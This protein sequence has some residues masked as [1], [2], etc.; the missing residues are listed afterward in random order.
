[1]CKKVS[2]Y[3][4]LEKFWAAPKLGALIL[5]MRGVR[6]TLLTWEHQKST[7]NHQIQWSWKWTRTRMETSR[8]IR[9]DQGWHL[10]SRDLIKLDFKKSKSSRSPRF[11]EKCGRAPVSVVGF[12]SWGGHSWNLRRKSLWLMSRILHL[13]T[14]WPKET[15]WKGVST[16]ATGGPSDFWNLLPGGECFALLSLLLLF[17]F[18]YYGSSCSQPAVNCQPSFCWGDP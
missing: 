2:L 18:S 4:C 9:N 11:C 7:R 1:M 13:D 12:R 10:T 16:I 3:I 15:W 6:N 8:G 14:I 5:L 17:F